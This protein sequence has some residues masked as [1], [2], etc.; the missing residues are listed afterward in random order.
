[1]SKNADPVKYIHTGYGTGFDSRLGLLFKDGS[2]G[3]IV[4]ISRV[5][6]CSSAYTVL[7]I[8]KKI[9]IV[10]FDQLFNSRGSR[11]NWFF[12]IK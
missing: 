12:K 5:E 2:I 10:G 6:V 11:F 8:K 9:L 1:M 7:I 3:K 4:I